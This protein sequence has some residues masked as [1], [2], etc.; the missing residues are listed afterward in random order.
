MIAVAAVLSAWVVAGAV[1]LLVD[2]EQ[3]REYSG[4]CWITI[5]ALGIIIPLLW[6]AL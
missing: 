2:D 4:A 1:M 3:S 5:S 6:S